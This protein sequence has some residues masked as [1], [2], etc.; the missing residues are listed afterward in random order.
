M[1][2][3]IDNIIEEINEYREEEENLSEEWAVKHLGDDV[4]IRL[5]Q[6]DVPLEDSEITLRYLA[7]LH[8]N[9]STIIEAHEREEERA[10][11]GAALAHEVR[12]LRY[13]LDDILATYK[14]NIE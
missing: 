13:K 3:N 1:T 5:K 2:N 6:S 9:I 12:K 11:A 10:E 7:Y 14:N 8:N 4:E